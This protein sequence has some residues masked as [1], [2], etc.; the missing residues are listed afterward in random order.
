MNRRVRH[1]TAGVSLGQTATGTYLGDYN[2]Y[3][4]ESFEELMIM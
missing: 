1:A 2:K 4:N 3:S